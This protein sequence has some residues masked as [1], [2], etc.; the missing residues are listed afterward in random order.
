MDRNTPYSTGYALESQIREAYGRI[1]YTQTCHNK[2]VN[3]LLAKNEYIKVAQIVLSALTTSSFGAIF[4]TGKPIATLIGALLSLGLLVLNS[5]TKNFDLVETAQGHR[6]AA[7]ALWK[8][9]EEYISLLTDFD[10][11]DSDEIRNI[12]DDLQE[13]TGKVYEQSPSTDAKSFKQAQKALKTNEEQTFSDN[14]LDLLIPNAI[15][16]SNRAS[17]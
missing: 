2:I 9:R 13:R 11:L 6:S 17:E 8:I 12:R 16:R 7:E 4:I 10:D 3:R 15:R 14:E 5:Y 1:L